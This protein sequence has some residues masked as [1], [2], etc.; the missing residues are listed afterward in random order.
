MRAHALLATLLLALSTAAQV[1][2]DRGVLDAL[3]WRE[4]HGAAPALS[5]S[6]SPTRGFDLHHHRLEW[7]L[8]PAVNFISGTVRSRFVATAPLSTLVFDADT[9][10]HVS[11]ALH[12]NDPLTFTHTTDGLLLIDLPAPLTPGTADSVTVVYSG[13][14]SGSGF[15]SF[16]VGTPQGNTAQWTL[17]E[18]YGARDWWPCKQ[19]LHDKIDSIDVLLTVPAAYE[20]VSNGV[21]LSVTPVNGGVQRVHHWR[22]RH[23]IAYYLIATATCDYTVSQT[24]IPLVGDT[25]AMWTYAYP[26]D[27]YMAQL[28]AGDVAQQMPFY[29]SRFG[30]YPFADEQYGHA[31]FGWGGGM[32][33]QTMTFMGGW[34][35]ELAAHE[36]AHQWF[37]DKVTCGSWQ[38]LWLNE[39]FATYLSG[40][41]YETLAPQYWP[42]WKQAQVADIT[43]L[44]DGS[45]LVSDTT[46]IARLFSARLTYRKGAM[47]LHM[48][49]WLCGDSAFFAGCRN[50]LNDPLLAYANAH[51]AD[52]QAHLE[53]ASGLDLDGFMADWYTGQG[54]PSYTVEWTQDGAGNVSLQLFQ[55]S[56][57][58]S[59]DFFELPVPL[60]F[61][62][63][64]QDSLVVL[65]HDTNGQSFSLWLPFQADSVL[66]DPDTWLISGQNLVLRVP[67][68]AQADGRAVLY[69]NPTTGDALLYLGGTHQGLAEVRIHDLHGRLL[70]RLPDRPIT[71]RRIALPVA[72]LAAGIYL[73]EA[74]G[75]RGVL[76]KR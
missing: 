49:R 65:D 53:A 16:A 24:L 21:L 4:R 15:G 2:W 22:H 67:S 69:P 34:S 72:D 23:P 17:S 58:P 75:T 1:A 41:C 6:G 50:Y 43:S 12:G 40:L 42:G 54:H 3:A 62:N 36:L 33:H 14:P 20:A 31:Q 39:G 28:V 51:T 32:E 9:A 76:V 29:S 64:A 47:V 37:G 38:D 10:L 71:D 48:L 57:H 35:Y 68:L 73:V 11:A 56:S 66:L 8:D 45:V 30:N 74:A 27:D 44:P 63:N 13:A 59:V 55:S 61:K 52:L 18:P 26:Q 60:R 46:D 5:R 19:D 25:V 70:R 7:T